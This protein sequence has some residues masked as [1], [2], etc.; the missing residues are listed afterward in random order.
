MQKYKATKNCEKGCYLIQ[1]RLRN[2]FVYS[3]FVQAVDSTDMMALSVFFELS[4]GQLLCDYDK[5]LKIVQPLRI[6]YWN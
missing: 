6:I 3:L 1:L 2:I 4:I 5:I